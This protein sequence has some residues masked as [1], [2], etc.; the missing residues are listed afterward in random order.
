MTTRDICN[1]VRAL[2]KPYPGAHCIY[3]GHEYKVWKVEPAICS[4]KNIE[5]GKILNLIGNIIEVK[6]ADASIFIYEHEIFD[7]PVV[8]TYFL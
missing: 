5:P 1:L 2:S 8:N 3:G 7:L 4:I 6:T